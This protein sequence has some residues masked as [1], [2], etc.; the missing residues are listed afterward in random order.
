MMDGGN[1]FILSIPDTAAY[2]LHDSQRKDSRNTP[3]GKMPVK[4]FLGLVCR[5]VL[6]YTPG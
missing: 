4:A 3:F 6:Q 2:V 1:D 5:G